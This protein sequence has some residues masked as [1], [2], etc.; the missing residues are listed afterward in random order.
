MNLE[1][2][3]TVAVQGDRAELGKVKEALSVLFDR[4]VALERDDS[5]HVCGAY[6][7]IRH[8]ERNWRAVAEA[9]GISCMAGV[10]VDD[11]SRAVIKKYRDLEARKNSTEAG[12]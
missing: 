2:A 5:E 12:A 10:D 1:E 3:K 9:L 7:I 4:V 8:H 11:N 6:E